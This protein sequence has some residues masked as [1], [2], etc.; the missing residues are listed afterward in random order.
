MRFSTV[1]MV[2]AFV[3]GAILYADDGHSVAGDPKDNAKAADIAAA[4]NVSVDSIDRL[5]TAY[6]I[7]YGGISKAFALA[8]KSGLSVD[9][10]LQMKTG[11]KLGWGEIARKLESEPGKDYK[12]E[13]PEVDRNDA[14][15]EKQ[16][17]RMEN[18]VEKR[19]EKTE[20]KMERSP[21]KG[22]K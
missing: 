21:V 20:R 16:Q 12:I 22:S 11:D 5:K 1:F 4:C 2:I 9:A 10:I 15:M 17:A 7:G 18:R 13:V 3:S 14:Q 6:S 19:S 8:Q